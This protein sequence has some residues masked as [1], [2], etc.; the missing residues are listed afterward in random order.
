MRT[1]AFTNE[2]N[3]NI[4]HEILSSVGLEKF[5]SYITCLISD[6][7]FKNTEQEIIQ[8][9]V[10]VVLQQ[11]IIIKKQ[12]SDN[13][14]LHEA[15]DRLKFTVKTLQTM[16][17]GSQSEKAQTINNDKESSEDKSDKVDKGNSNEKETQGDDQSFDKDKRKRNSNTDTPKNY[18]K[19]PARNK[20][21]EHLTRVDIVHKAQCH[22][23]ICAV[24][25]IETGMYD[26]SEE[27]TVK[28]LMYVLR[29]KR[30]KLKPGCKCS[31]IPLIYTSPKIGSVIHKSKYSNSLISFLLM[32]KFY[33]QVPIHRQRMKLFWNYGSQISEGTINGIFKVLH[34]QVFPQFYQAIKMYTLQANHFHGDETSWKVFI[35]KKGKKT[36]NHWIWVVASK[37]GITY[38][39]DPTRSKSVVLKTFAP[40]ASGIINVDRYASYNALPE[41]LLR[42]FCWY[43]LRRDFIRL[44]RGVPALRKW[45][46][47]WIE[48]I[49]RIEKLN[50]ARFEAYSKIDNTAELSPEFIRLHKRL[51]ILLSAFYNRASRLVEDNKL[52]TLAHKVLISLI[53]HWDGYMVFYE[54][55]F[56]PMHNNYSERLLRSVANARNNFLGSHSAW[57]AELMAMVLSI[58]ETAK[59]HGL[60]PHTYMEYLLTQCSLC[61]DRQ[62]T[63]IQSVLPWNI[64][65]DILKPY[66]NMQS[67]VPYIP[68]GLIN[69]NAST[70]DITS[71]LQ[72]NFEER[73][74]RADIEETNDASLLQD[75]C[76][77]NQSLDDKQVSSFE[78]SFNSSKTP[79]L[80]NVIQPSTEI[81]HLEKLES[82]DKIEADKFDYVLN[83]CNNNTPLPDAVS[84]SICEHIHEFSYAH[85]K[86]V[87]N[88]PNLKSSV[89]TK[90]SS[91]ISAITLTALLILFFFIYSF[92]DSSQQ[93][94]SSQLLKNG[95]MQT[96][97]YIDNSD[98]RISFTQTADEAKFAITK[99]ILFVGLFP[100]TS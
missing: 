100:D 85:A 1:Q 19:R 60:N 87:T 58:C 39:Y 93:L 8:S 15:C 14:K 69:E 33:M 34:E 81:S 26:C 65:A 43:H 96:V 55:P 32:N 46:I 98:Q 38:I 84:A 25:Y 59:L 45:A 12:E 77:S 30:I 29:H 35:D 37:N 74:L 5:S 23:P 47:K 10:K 24:E 92:G 88:I 6:E 49:R 75:I 83:S 20:I 89:S 41:K 68:Q 54:Y 36:F 94:Y 52:H 80:R 31:G 97:Y 90:A 22:C 40:D 71:S 13:K 21:P 67:L 11:F 57:S 28:L 27:L 62:I 76:A 78:R 16:Q 50:N 42:S 51:Y 53:K 3:N 91:R 82:L 79:P 44:A 70:S 95:F 7:S 48:T 63:D 64:S 66:E 2:I 61:E 17:F 56:V 9:L 72:D 18:K 86:N 4:L 99:K 73:N